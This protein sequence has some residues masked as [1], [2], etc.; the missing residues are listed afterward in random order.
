MGADVY[1]IPQ[2]TAVDITYDVTIVCTK[3]RDLNKFNKIIIESFS[4]R[5]TYTSVKGHYI[6]IVLDSIE[7]NTPM[8][9]LDGRRFYL[10]TYKMTLL[11]FILDPE[12][13]EVTPA[14]SRIFVMEEFLGEQFYNK[15]NLDAFG[16]ITFATFSGSTST[17]VNVEEPIGFLIYV[18]VNGILQI[19]DINYYHIS[20]TPKV[21]LVNPPLTTD[22]IELLYYNGQ[23]VIPRDMNGKR[24]FLSKENFVYDGTS[25]IFNTNFNIKTIVSVDFNGLIQ[26]EGVNYSVTNPKEITL[27]EIPVEGTRIGVTYFY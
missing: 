13:F 23:N 16:E 4:S 22:V 18:S 12:E 11:G 14:I 25:L 9:T 19:K 5:Q 1:K 20:Q 26:I 17:V 8:E 6:P 3:F 15:K 10:Q 7:D 27:L 24:I 2:P 21:T